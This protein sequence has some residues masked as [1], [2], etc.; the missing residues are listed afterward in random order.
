[1]TIASRE[2]T[3]PKARFSPNHHGSFGQKYLNTKNI[4]KL[5]NPDPNTRAD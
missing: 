5:G 1:L 2:K 3:I 4:S